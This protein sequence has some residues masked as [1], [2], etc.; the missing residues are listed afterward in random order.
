LR[1]AGSWGENDGFLHVFS[2]PWNPISGHGCLIGHD[3]AADTTTSE[4][5]DLTIAAGQTLIVAV[6]SY[7]AGEQFPYNLTIETIDPQNPPVVDPPV[8]PEP[9]ATAE[10]G[11]G[12]IEAGEICDGTS[13]G[14]ATCSSQGYDFGVVFCTSGCQ[15]GLGLCFGLGE[16]P[17]P[18]ADDPV[19]P[20]GP[21]TPVKEPGL[22]F[23]VSGVL[24]DSDPQ[25]TR[26]TES[27]ST[28]S[29]QGQ[30]FDTHRIVNNSGSTRYLDI[31]ANWDGDGFIAVYTSDF[32]PSAPTS[33]CLDA[34]DD[35]TAGPAA[36]R[37]GS[38][39]SDFAIYPNEELV[40]VATTFG[41][42]AKIGDYT[43][44][45]TS[46]RQSTGEAVA[47]IAA[48]GGSV[49]T[50]GT[51]HGTDETWNRLGSTCTSSPATGEHSRDRLLIKNDTGSSQ[52]LDITATWHDGDGY[53]HVF[54]YDESNAGMGNGMCLDANDDSNGQ[55]E[56]AVESL[57]IYS[58][59]TL[60]VVASS[61]AADTPIGA[62]DIEVAT[63]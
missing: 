47:S 41:A 11:N 28:G 25:W 18:P 51:L 19:T 50:S 29:T 45:V 5:N 22:A 49:T 6:S 34:D 53:L 54:V 20:V 1:V 13:L 40:I 14:G 46:Q 60:L 2:S 55:G 17:E 52:D 32:D 24:D 42:D 63:R 3:D 36:S 61:Y 31:Q 23:S 9:G 4:I 37:M 12:V 15:L 30:R 58:G 16:E 26:P 57:L 39:V 27:C 48:P 44:D 56:S 8:Q 43:I 59:E 7:N 35:F 62:Y 10:C 38:K 21:V 33:G